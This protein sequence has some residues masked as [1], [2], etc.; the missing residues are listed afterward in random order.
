MTS[1]YCYM[2]VYMNDHAPCGIYCR[3]CPGVKFYNC[4]GCRQQEGKVKD[5]PV[6]KTY[7]CVSEKGYKFCFE[8]DDFPCIKLQPIVNFEIFLPHNSK[9]YNL[10]MIQKH[11]IAKWNEI[12]E[13]KTILYYDGRKV[14]FGGDPL[15]LEKKDSGM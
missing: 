10:L 3:R 15:T 1:R 5:F 2:S 9:I 11:G 8:C 13:D 6:C 4:E 14:K 7:Q 12:C